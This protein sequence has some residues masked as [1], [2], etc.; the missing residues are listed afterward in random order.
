MPLPTAPQIEGTSVTPTFAVWY[1]SA[2]M[3]TAISASDIVAIP[4]V[5]HAASGN[6]DNPLTFGDTSES[7]AS[8]TL[9]WSAPLA[10]AITPDTPLKI[11]LGYSGNNIEAFEGVSE[12]DTWTW[13][14]AT[15]R[16]RLTGYAA[17]V[18]RCKKPTPLYIRRRAFTRTTISSVENPAAVGYRAGY[19]NRL[20]WDAGGRPIDQA[21]T[22][23]AD[24][25]RKFWYACDEA[26][27]EIPYAWALSGEDHWTQ[28]QEAARAAGGQ[29]VQRQ[30][31]VIQYWNPFHLTDDIPA[32][33]WHLDETRFDQGGELTRTRSYY[34]GCGTQIVRYTQRAVQAEQEIY[35]L[36]RMRIIPAGGGPGSGV[37]GEVVIPIKTQYPIARCAGLDAGATV[38][39]AN[40]VGAS[41]ID[42]ANAQITPAQNGATGNSIHYIVD[43]GLGRDAAQDFAIRVRSTWPR[44]L[45]LHDFR[46][47]GYPLMAVLQGEARDGTEEPERTWTEGELMQ[48]EVQATRFAAMSR[49]F[50]GQQRPIWEQRKAFYDPRVQKGDWIEVSNSR[51]G[52][53]HEPF[54]IVELAPT[55]DGRFMDL[56]LLPMAGIPRRDEFYRVGQT[57]G[58][59]WSK[60][61]VW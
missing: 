25:A 45:Q 29:I 27:I 44:P 3:W 33:P 21:V 41:I 23:A 42:F 12:S 5:R 36:D 40:W 31:G 10:S 60:K 34:E 13:S 2:G 50:Y 18:A 22:Y 48:D 57:Y 9:F 14:D 56:R 1:L 6:V 59:T 28:L 4:Q 49:A 55:D 11:E 51:F 30:D 26:L 47:R 52:L 53:D 43:Q 61:M 16:L 8:L 35:K 58:A 17:L 39:L 32:T 38:I 37:Y 20:L 15:L 46:L 7:D 24:P 54:T 19:G